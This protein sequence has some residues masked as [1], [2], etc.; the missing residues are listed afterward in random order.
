MKPA[1]RLSLRTL[2]RL[3]NPTAPS[4]LIHST[5]VKPA[6]VAPILGTGPPP[7]APPAPGAVNAYHRVE[8]RRRQAELLKN[9]K[10]LRDAKS[11]KVGGMLKKRF[12][13]NVSVHEVDGE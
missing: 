5:V 6:N 7:D 1:A 4:R 3:V 13:K 11:G 8:R 12:W 2:P 9:A 10:H